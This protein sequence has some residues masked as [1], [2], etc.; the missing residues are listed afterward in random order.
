MYFNKSY[1]ETNRKYFYLTIWSDNN[2]IPGSIIY[3]RQAIRPEFENEL[4]KFHTYYIDDA[5]IVLNGVFY[6]GWIQTTADFLNL[7]FDLNNNHKTNN[8]YNING[9]WVNSSYS[10]SWMIR[11]FFGKML[12]TAI[13]PVKPVEMADVNIYPNPTKDEINI[14]I[15]NQND[16]QQINVSIYN[17]S[18]ILVHQSIISNNQS[19]DLSGLTN[20]TYFIKLTDKSKK[21]DCT[22]KIIKLN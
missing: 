8:F 21:L 18:G 9:K 20:G 15:N 11:P 12:T 13:N 7:G 5:T 17:I 6:V 1:L 10:G 2:G 19:I 3:K 16:Y 14:K 4:N 22:K